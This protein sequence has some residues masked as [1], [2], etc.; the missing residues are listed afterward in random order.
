VTQEQATEASAQAM[1]TLGFQVTQKDAQK[2]LVRT[3]PKPF[4]ESAHAT[5]VGSG[6]TATASAVSYEDAIAWDIKID[7]SSDGVVLHAMPR[8]YTNGNDVTERG[9]PA[10]AIDPKFRD[11]FRELDASMSSA[12]VPTTPEPALGPATATEPTSTN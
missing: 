8:A 1:A 5:A 10:E 12:A 9:L 6:N 11:L 4:M 7:S 3:A 2:G